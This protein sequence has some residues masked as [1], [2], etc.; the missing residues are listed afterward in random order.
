VKQSRN[1]VVADELRRLSALPDSVRRRTALF[2]P[3]DQTAYW[4][5]LTRRGA[6]AFQSFVATALTSMA[7]IDGM[8][9]V[10][11]PLV[12]YY[13]IGSFTPRTRPQVPEDATPA[14]LCRRA[15]AWGIDRVITLRFDQSR[16]ASTTIECPPTPSR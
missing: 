7:M 10:G 5:S 3:Q 12:P 9:A 4:N 8:P 16:A 1:F 14:T 6:C 11:C 13:G 2:I 15:A